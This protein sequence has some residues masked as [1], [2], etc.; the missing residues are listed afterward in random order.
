M[1]LDPFLKAN[2][3][4]SIVLVGALGL[5]AV[6]G[7]SVVRAALLALAVSF[8]GAS[9]SALR[10]RRWAVAVVVIAAPAVALLWTPTVVVNFWLF[11]QGDTRYR[12]SPATIL[13]VALYAVLFA[14]PSCMLAVGYGLNRKRIVELFRGHKNESA[15]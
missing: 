8:A 3:A 2:A 15:A 10:H 12:D 4:W 5:L 14:L 1:T 9:L 13:V 7:P 6:G 11:A